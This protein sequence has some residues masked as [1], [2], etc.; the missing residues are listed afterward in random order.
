MHRSFW[1]GP[2]LLL[3]SILAPA[4]P[5]QAAQA[6]PA[7]IK[8]APPPSYQPLV[9]TA[10][11]LPIVYCYQGMVSDPRLVVVDKSRQRLL[12]FQYLGQLGL[13]YEYPCASGGQDGKK[14]VSADQRTPEGV[15]FITHRFRDR[16]ITIFGDRALHLNYPNASD[17][18]QGRK[19]DGIYIHGSNRRFK[20]RSSNGCLVLSNQDLAQVEPLIREQSTPVIVVDRLDLPT[21]AERERACDFL[22]TL[23]LR[24]LSDSQPRLPEALSLLKNSAKGADLKT[25]AQDL[26]RLGAGTA[27][28]IE[29]LALWGVGDQWVLM[30]H[31]TWGGTGKHKKTVSV[32]RLFYMEGPPYQTL[33]VL[34]RQWV[35]ADL[36]QARLLA[37]WA[38][39]KPVVV[40][41]ARPAPAAVGSPE[42]QIKKMLDGWM[43]AWQSKRLRQY[44]AYYAKDFRG[45]DRNWRQWRRHKAYLN[46]VYKKIEVKTVDMK[47]KISGGRATVSFVQHYRSDHHRDKGLKTLQLVQRQGR[48]QIQREDWQPVS[49]GHGQ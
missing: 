39:P 29:G 26:S 3:V 48:W 23:D 45:G 18:V 46:R 21:L 11:S 14:A 13:E 36:P 5:L 30:L 32:R 28:K 2:V 35:L 31:Q 7:E 25:L 22:R 16:K 44:M 34:Q 49:G 27:A 41:A 33:K 19:G 8:P 42:Q 43:A 17:Q 15:Y 37:S 24:L 38:P 6:T 10:Q 9:R 20:K 40:A 47:I 12:V 4:L 1:W